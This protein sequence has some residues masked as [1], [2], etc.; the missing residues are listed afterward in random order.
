MQRDQVYGLNAELSN[1]VSKNWTTTKEKEFEKVFQ[2]ATKN[3]N[4]KEDA[5]KIAAEAAEKMLDT[6]LENIHDYAGECLEKD[7]YIAFLQDL[8]RKCSKEGN[9]FIDYYLKKYISESKDIVAAL[10]KR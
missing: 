3:G 2:D 8:T 5:K 4:S 10:T 7:I 6:W 1:Y 9:D